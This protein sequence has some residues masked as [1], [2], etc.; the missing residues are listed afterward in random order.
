M[1]PAI[2]MEIKGKDGN[3][4]VR[5]VPNRY[6]AVMSSVPGTLRFDN[7][8][9]LIKSSGNH[10]VIIESPL[11]DRTIEMMSLKEVGHLIEAYHRRYSDLTKDRRNKTV[12]LFRNHGKTAGR[13]LSHPHSQ[14]IT[15]GIIPRAIRVRQI[16]FLSYRRGNGRCLLCDIIEFELLMFCLIY[17][18][19]FIRG[20]DSS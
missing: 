6:S 17:S 7:M 16:N 15:L 10:E 9:R 11:H 18:R 2:L 20:M 3:W 1:L 8:Y 4:Q 14:I 19:S 5:V 12:I 13:S